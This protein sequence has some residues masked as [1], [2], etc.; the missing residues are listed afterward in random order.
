MRFQRYYSH[1][2]TCP[3]RG[4]AE[5]AGS[6]FVRSW[7]HMMIRFSRP[8]TYFISL[9]SCDQGEFS[10]V[11]SVR[12]G[13]VAM[14]IE[15][16]WVRIEEFL[17]HFFSILA[18][19]DVFGVYGKLLS[20][21]I[22]RCRNRANRRRTRRGGQIISIFGLFASIINIGLSNSIPFIPPSFP[23]ASNSFSIIFLSNWA[24]FGVFLR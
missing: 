19:H 12:I 2:H 22:Q 18:T 20:R 8:S 23:L 14:E 4:D 6:L 17:H 3:V 5:L 16:K 15:P 9:E 7:R 11:G 21:G 24:V 10:A 13:S 1:S